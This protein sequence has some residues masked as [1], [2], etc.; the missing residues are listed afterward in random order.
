VQCVEDPTQVSQG[1]EQA[2]SVTQKIRLFIPSQ[3]LFELAK[4]PRLQEE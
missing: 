4:K 2:N 1:V 3:V